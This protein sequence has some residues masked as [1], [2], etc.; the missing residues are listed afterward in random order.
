[1]FADY[2]T[3]TVFSHGAGT[4]AQNA[5]AA[6][7]R[8]LEAVGIA[9]HGPANWF[10]VGV[11]SLATFDRLRREV[12]RCRRQFSGL[13]ILAG[14]EANI[15]SFEG[16]LDVPAA[17]QRQLDQ[18]LVGFH[19]QVTPKSW[20]TGW[21][22][23]SGSLLARLSKSQR[24]RARTANTKAI[25]EAMARNRIDIITHPG[26]KV[27]IDTTELARASARYGVALEI[28]ARHGVQSLGFV[29]AAARA[30]AVF[31]IGSD[32]HHPAAVGRLDPAI[33]VA[34]AA[35]LDASQIINA[36]PEGG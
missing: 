31:A 13:R 22:F 14:T 24:R 6:G 8:G 16:H 34:E 9:D 35:G 1:M 12:D 30:G 18:V 36:Y 33:R 26:L 19:T 5:R 10:G 4:V 28:N 21:R 29:R 23:V 25:V 32:A 11:G 7:I 2:H 27:A 3:H 20:Q 17:V 15:I